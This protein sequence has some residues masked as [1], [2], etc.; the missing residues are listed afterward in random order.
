MKW[1]WCAQQMVV[2]PCLMCVDEAMWCRAKRCENRG[3]TAKTIGLSCGEVRQVTSHTRCWAGDHSKTNSLPKRLW[4]RRNNLSTLRIL[5]IS[6][7]FSIFVRVETLKL[8]SGTIL[9]SATQ[10]LW[11]TSISYQRQFSV[12]L[13]RYSYLN[14]ISSGYGM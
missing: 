6:S 10:S 14:Y 12:P 1:Q 11:F 3:R 7:H 2:M 4:R 9:W 8:W 5:D 13:E